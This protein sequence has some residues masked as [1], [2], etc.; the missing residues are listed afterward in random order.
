MRN[1]QVINM[2]NKSLANPCGLRC[3]INNDD[4][5]IV[6][7]KL[8]AYFRLSDIETE[9]D[10]KCKVLEWLSFYVANNHWFGHDKERKN[11]EHFINYILGT[12]FNHDDFQYIYCELGNRVNHQ[13]T[14]SFIE[15]NYDMNLLGKVVLL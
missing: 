13:L 4:E 5:L 15:S 11:I 1:P 2:I 3:F 14:I 10:F 8:N 7:P 6:S 9:L 12:H